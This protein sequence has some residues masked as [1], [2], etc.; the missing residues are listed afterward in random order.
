MVRT[1][2]PVNSIQSSRPGYVP[3]EIDQVT[4]ARGGRHYLVPN[5]DGS[6]SKLPS[7]TSILSAVWP[8]PFIVNWQAKLRQEAMESYLRDNLGEIITEETISDLERE[9]DSPAQVRDEAARLGVWAH[10]VFGMRLNGE[11]IAA[12]R[13]PTSK[14]YDSV[15]K[16]SAEDV[17]SILAGIESTCTY[18]D[19][20]GWRV[21]DVETAMYA[22]D[23]RTGAG[24]AGTIDAI[25]R[26]E[27]GRRLLVE[28]KTSK[29]IYVEAYLQAAAYTWGLGDVDVMLVR[30][31][32]EDSQLKIRKLSHTSIEN[33]EDHW[34]HTFDFYTSVK[35]AK[36]SD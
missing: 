12:Y 11:D 17:E 1:K 10:D 28:V 23:Y 8:K 36:T 18:L 33:Y 13:D 22:Q 35:G 20:G 6:E 5:E 30:L 32:K 34:S 25:L 26:R 15:M 14:K 29:D 27:D 3:F 16:F 4:S 31:P 24:Y 7:V 21:T 2:I 9:L 19:D